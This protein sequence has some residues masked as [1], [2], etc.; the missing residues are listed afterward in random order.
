MLSELRGGPLHTVLGV[1][2]CAFG[3]ASVSKQQHDHPP[4]GVDFSVPDEER[5]WY[6]KLDGVKKQTERIMGGL[7]AWLSQS[8]ERDGGVSRGSGA[9][10]KRSS[11]PLCPTPFWASC[12]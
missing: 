9:A 2:G 7:V 5:S 1:R 12:W 8:E 4:D 3:G 11:C 6:P 10:V